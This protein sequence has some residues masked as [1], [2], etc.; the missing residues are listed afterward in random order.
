M[1]SSRINVLPPS[2][3]WN[4]LLSWLYRV[5]GTSEVLLM[6]W[7]TV[8]CHNPEYH[9]FNLYSCDNLKYYTLRWWRTLKRN[10]NVRTEEIW[11]FF[12]QI[13]S[14]PLKV[15]YIWK[16]IHFKSKTLIMLPENCIGSCKNISLA[17][18][19]QF[20]NECSSSLKF[21]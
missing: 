3:A 7:Q 15:L 17:H 9:N 18:F 14:T 19:T 6:T 11:I 5:A 2:S 8:Q 16:N 12:S 21:L 10:L 1:L 13:C 20:F 4:S